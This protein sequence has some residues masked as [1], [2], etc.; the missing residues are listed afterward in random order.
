MK[1]NTVSKYFFGWCLNEKRKALFTVRA[2]HLFV[3]VAVVCVC[4]CE[5]YV[6]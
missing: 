5:A 6:Q 2:V 1:I 4:V 3:C